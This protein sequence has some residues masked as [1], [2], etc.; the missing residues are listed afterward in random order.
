MYAPLSSSCDSHCLNLFHS[1]QFFYPFPSLQYF[2]ARLFEG[3]ALCFVHLLAIALVAAVMYCPLM[4]L[5]IE[6]YKIS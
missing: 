4:S 6:T 3:I 1:L 2:A 5:K